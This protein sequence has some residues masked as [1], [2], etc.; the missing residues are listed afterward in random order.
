MFMLDAM[1]KLVTLADRCGKAD[2]YHHSPAGQ[3]TP[4]H[5][6]PQ[7]AL[8]PLT[9]PALST[10]VTPDSLPPLP[11]C[12][13]TPF[14]T[15]DHYELVS[16]F[17]AHPQELKVLA[18][19]Q[20]WKLPE[21]LMSHEQMPEWK[22]PEQLL[23]QGQLAGLKAGLQGLM[24]A[25]DQLA[26]KKQGSRLELEPDQATVLASR[27]CSGQAAAQGQVSFACK[28]NQI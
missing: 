18:S 8:V 28:S 27:C 23:S 4:L 2:L 20:M 22:L 12:L 21:Q 11:L 6:L 13:Q 10:S 25:A 19:L 24:R 5:G 1:Q 7:Q 16:H 14:Q 9:P 15:H 17:L 3:L 26:Q